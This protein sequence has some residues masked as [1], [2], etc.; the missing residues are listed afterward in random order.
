MV[1]PPVFKLLLRGKNKSA[2]GA[3]LSLQN[4]AGRIS[5]GTIASG[6]GAVI[7][8]KTLRLGVVAAGS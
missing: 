2:C 3:H 1:V 8:S 4:R 7:S 5:S 6:K